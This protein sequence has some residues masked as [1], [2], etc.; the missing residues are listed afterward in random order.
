[1]IKKNLKNLSLQAIAQIIPRAI[2]FLFIF[3]LA[4]ILGKEGYGR[5]ELSLSIGYLIGVFFE[6]GGNVI[7]TKHVARGYYSS[8]NYAL[9]FR[10]VS[11]L[12]TLTIFFSILFIFN[13]YD[14]LRF[15]IAYAVLGI[16]FSSLMNLYFAFYRGIRQM[17]YE[18]LVLV[19]Q[20]ILFIAICLL[21]LSINNDASMAL[22]GFFIS[23][24]ISWL[25][26]QTIFFR[27]KSSYI[28]EGKY[29]KIYFKEYLRDVLSLALV[30]IFAIIYFRLTQIILEAYRGI[31]EVGIYAA[32]Y[33]LIE[34][35]TNVPS[36]IMIV[37]FPTFAKL[38]VENITDFKKEFKRL[39]FI[40]ILLG[41]GASA[42]CWIFGQAF[43]SIIGSQYA[44]SHLVL[45]YLTIPMLAIYP[46]YLL[47]QSL[48]ALDKNIL[49]A[50]LL[51]SVLILNI[52][53]SLMIVPQYGVYG[54]AISVGICEWV[55]FVIGFIL[56]F[57]II[58]EVEGSSSQDP[59]KA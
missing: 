24:F 38:A 10:I 6:L 14:D 2:L 18:A 44:E 29:N 55:I 37:L 49:Y 36:I 45:R 35:L 59:T 5:F 50:F 25:I 22:L 16:A 48:I 30:D 15:Y 27:H 1:M 54:S 58:K 32:S 26:I 9:K 56:I 51:L 52:F 17:K 19:I 7:L 4:R 39:L 13:L 3:Y 12:L 31:D 42:F 47:T 57:R 11:I 53:I 21:L 33:R 46:N 20:K 28:D 43:Y 34:A 23:M 41:V 8:F 40:L